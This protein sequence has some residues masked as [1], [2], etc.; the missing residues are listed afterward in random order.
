[1]KKG[2]FVLLAVV[3]VCGLVACSK[4][5]EGTKTSEAMLTPGVSTL[6]AIKE[7]G[8]LVAGV[9]DSVVPFGYVDEK[10]GELVGFDV[11]LCRYI[12]DELGVK[13]KLQPVTSS[14][15]IPMLTEGKVDLLAATMTHK[16]ERDEVIDFSVTY[17]MDGQRLL[18]PAGGAIKSYEDLAGKKVGSVKGSTSEKNILMVQPAADVISFEGYPEAFL[19]LK[20]GKVVAVTT[21]SVILVG[22]K[23]SDPDPTKWEVAGDF[24]SSEPYAIGVRENDSEWRD[25]VNFTLMKMYKEGE[26]EKVYN[27]WLGPDT[28]YYLPPTDWKMEIWP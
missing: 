5:P 27:K 17:F 16:I 21:D 9:K 10:S 12:A 14:N 26:W 8:V 20:Q 3:F 22:L 15:R 24:F 23:G 4:A 7:K 1:M 28:N 19:A 25:F 11:D 2:I 6:D 18:V 13:L